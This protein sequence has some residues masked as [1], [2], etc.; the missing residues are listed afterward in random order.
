[1][2]WTCRRTRTSTDTRIAS[3]TTRQ[4][5]TTRADSGRP[6]RRLTGAAA[7]A[8]F[9]AILFFSLGMHRGMVLSSDIKSVRFPWAP[10]LP[11]ATLQAPALSDPVWQFLPWLAL[12]RR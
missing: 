5:R 3:R 1:R 12:A 6:V 2:T 9:G 8:A 11:H 4:R 10:Y 7:L